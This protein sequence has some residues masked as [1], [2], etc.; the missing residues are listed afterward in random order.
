MPWPGRSSSD[1][2]RD[3]DTAAPSTGDFDTPL[4]EG[5]PGSQTAQAREAH[6]YMH[7]FSASR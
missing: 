5:A 2:R 3:T 1:Q 7:T 6:A 4:V